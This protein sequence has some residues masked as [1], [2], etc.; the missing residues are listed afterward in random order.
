[1]R[2]TCR[3]HPGS[4]RPTACSPFAA[5]AITWALV[6]WPLAAG[7]VPVPD[8]PAMT[9]AM[10]VPAT[11]MTVVEPHLSTRERPVQVRYRGWPAAAVL[12]K[13]LGPP[14]RAT[15]VEVEFR[16]LDGYVSRIPN[17]RFLRYGAWL[18]YERTGH[19]AFVLDNRQQN[20]KNVQLG[21]YYLV[22]DN[23]GHSELLP[24]GASYWPYQVAEIQVSQARMKALLPSGIAPGFEAS[25]A[26]AQQYCLS[27]HRI[28]GYGGD[29]APGNLAQTARA[30]PGREFLRWVLQPNQLKPGTTMPGLPDSMAEADRHAV[31]QRLMDY[32][33]AVPVQ[34]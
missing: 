1:M 13:L 5:L 32:L 9:K 30:M 6:A 26:L 2:S 12:D 31:A 10:G 25:A 21:P 33:V 18:V 19:T 8:L 20:E 11:T 14:W 4:G 7:A 15:G 3:T 27:C 22:W 28:N 29:K 34:P 17:Q 23:I 16:A 24:E